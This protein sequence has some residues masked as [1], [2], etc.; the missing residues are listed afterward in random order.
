[1]VTNCLKMI[2]K[3]VDNP[4]NQSWDNVQFQRFA[5]QDVSLYCTEGRKKVDEENSD[6]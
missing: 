2:D 5:C 1:M 4:E 6:K 3:K